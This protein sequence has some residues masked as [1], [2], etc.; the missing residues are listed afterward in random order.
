MKRTAS[1]LNLLAFLLVFYSGIS[2]CQQVDLSGT[3]VG[4]TEVPGATEPDK[5]TLVFE[6]KDG[7]YTGKISDSMGMVQDAECEDLEFEDNTLTFNFLVNTGEEY[8]RVDV[9]LTVE[10]DKMKG[11]WQTEDGSSGSIELEK[12][13]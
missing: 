5:L 11:D 13:K 4:E 3:W 12:Q 10:G 1:F 8:L 7:E 2:F 6:K 9:T